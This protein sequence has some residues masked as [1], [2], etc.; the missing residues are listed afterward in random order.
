LAKRRGVKLAMQPQQYHDA[1]YLFGGP[2][3]AQAKRVFWSDLKKL[4]P[5]WALVGQDPRRAIS[6][7]ELTILLVT[8]AMIQVIGLDAPQRAEG[9]PLDFVAVDEAADV[10]EEAWMEHLRPGLS[11]RGGQA[12][13]CG[14]PEGRNWFWRLA[15]KAQECQ[16]PAL[17]S[18]HTWPSSDILSA[19]EIEIAKAELDSRTFFQ[20]Y[21]ASFL[22]VTGR[23]YYG[24]ARE[25]HAVERMPYDPKA[26]LM[27]GFDFNV[28]PGVAVFMQERL[29][30]GDNALVPQGSL[31][32]AVVD[33]IWI[34]HDS[35]TPRVC[36]EIIRRYRQH[37][38]PLEVFGD[39]TGGARGTA[40]T[41]GSDLDL[42][43]R[44][45]DPVFNDRTVPQG[46]R[47]R[48][49]VPRSNP[50]VRARINAV[51]SRLES[52]DGK[53]HLLVDPSCR[54]VIE[55]LEGVTWSDSGD[56]DKKSSPTLSHISD[57]LGYV[58]A[59]KW[60]VVSREAVVYQ[61]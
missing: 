51:N 36:Q 17:W 55:D 43:R 57:A 14:T 19:A 61:V 31:I 29:Y 53:V 12:W 21:M 16:D 33:E 47:L 9:V 58:I 1:R 46:E 22:D 60:P 32:G 13:L 6:E 11:E 44:H 7:G 30:R 39:A 52:A 45:L 15:T 5:K 8:G 27:I 54:H 48:W 42:I 28:A 56:I 4:I 37:D 2:T 3:H 50:S 23:V 24:F 20:E 49:C 25:V 35:N 18:Y 41:D 26:T 10:R 59:E 34:E 40:Q 38:A